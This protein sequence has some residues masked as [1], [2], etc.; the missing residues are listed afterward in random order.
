MTQ[1]DGATCGA[2]GVDSEVAD[3][4]ATTTVAAIEGGS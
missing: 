1:T 3:G 4:F 2:D